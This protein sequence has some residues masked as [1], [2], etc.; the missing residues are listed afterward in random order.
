MKFHAFYDGIIIIII[1]IIAQLTTYSVCVINPGLTQTFFPTNSFPLS[2]SYAYL[3]FFLFV[4]LLFYSFT[5]FF[6]LEIPVIRSAEYKLPII[7]EI[8]VCMFSLYIKMK[9]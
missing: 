8:C 9:F 1:I 2:F 4:I 6:I 7:R 3:F 5:H